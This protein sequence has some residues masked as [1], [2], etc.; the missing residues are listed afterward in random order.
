MKA[1]A[2]D[3]EKT[4]LIA[5]IGAIIGQFVVLI[6]G[7]SK[8]KIDLNRKRKMIKA[9]LLKQDI[10]LESSEKKHV[11]LKTRLQNKDADEFTTSIF[12]TLQ[13][14]VYNSVA[15][16]ELFEIFGKDFTIIVDVYKSIDFIK[17]YGPF[18]I[19]K[20]YLE[21][22]DRHL[23]ETQNDEDFEFYSET[24]MGFIG[25][26]LKNIDNNLRTIAEVRSN[27]KHLAC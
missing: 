25:I 7:W 4:L 12:Q 1:E 5:L 18:W 21:K 17:N 3:W 8:R 22:S 27:I 15:K 16:N 19:Y 24:H 10:V 13:L 9:D 20:D 23:F 26:A 14:D 11:E 2:F 6:I